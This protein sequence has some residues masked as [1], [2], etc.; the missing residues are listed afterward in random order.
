MRS[1]EWEASTKQQRNKLQNLHRIWFDLIHCSRQNHS[2][3]ITFKRLPHFFPQASHWYLVKAPCALIKCRESVPVV[4]Y[5]FPHSLHLGF[6]APCSFRWCIYILC[7]VKKAWLHKVQ[8]NGR[9]PEC[10]SLWA[11]KQ[12]KNKKIKQ[13]KIMQ[14]VKNTKY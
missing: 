8:G 11:A 1:K 10:K 5:C 2:S 13:S 14:S 3:Y 12:T 6:S 7:L 9:S 4:I